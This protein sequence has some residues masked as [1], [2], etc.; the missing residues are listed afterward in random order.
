[1]D[2][3][4]IVVGTTEKDQYGNL[5]V[6]CK[7]GNQ[8][9]VNKKHEGL[10][11]L[12]EQGKA[13]KLHWETYQNKTYV[14]DAVLVEG[15]LPPPTHPGTSGAPIPSAEESSSTMSKKDWADKDAIARTSI[16]RQSSLKQAVNWCGIKVQAGKDLKTADVITCATLFEG[17]L[18]SG[19]VVKKS[20]PEP[21]S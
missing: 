11:H 6:T 19:A 8:V 4:I 2:D 18:K 12:F 1:M 16:E 17:Y 7:D 15:E 10:H 5:N 20:E 9:R 14:A 21:E 13:I 3:T